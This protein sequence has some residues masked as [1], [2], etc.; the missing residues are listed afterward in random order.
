MMAEHGAPCEGQEA[1]FCMNGGTCY[2]IPSMNTLS[3]VCNEDYKGSRCEEYQLQVKHTNAQEAGLIAAVVII[4]LLVLALLGLVIFYVRRMMK[5]KQ[6]SQQKNQH[7]YWK[8][9][10][11]V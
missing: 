4:A 3:C 5:A 9:K 7:E 2:K 10:P 8:V 1:T 11:R 6:Q